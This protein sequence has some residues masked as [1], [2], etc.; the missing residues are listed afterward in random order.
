MVELSLFSDWT[1]CSACGL[2]AA[3]EDDSTNDISTTRTSLSSTNNN[4]NNNKPKKKLMACAD[5][6]CVAYHNSSCQKS[7]WKT[8]H[9]R[10]CKELARVILPLKELIRWHRMNK[11]VKK[12]NRDA[13]A[14]DGSR[15]ESGIES[16]TFCCTDDD[17]DDGTQA[18]GENNNEG[19]RV[20]CWW[21][22]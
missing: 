22:K 19:K 14:S 1:Y 8:C 21:G 2:P 18:G 7:H 20:W 17:D 4:N 10:D 15:R 6:S 9:R 3:T 13:Q 11:R 16:I 5:C 12:N